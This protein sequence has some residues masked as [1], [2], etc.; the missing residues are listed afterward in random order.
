MHVSKNRQLLRD[1]VSQT[2][3]LGLG[4]WIP[5][6]VPQTPWYSLPPN[7]SILPTLLLELEYNV[8]C[9]I[10][11][12]VTWCEESWYEWSRF[13]QSKIVQNVCYN[14]RIIWTIPLEFLASNPAF[15]VTSV[16]TW[17]LNFIYEIDKVLQ[18]MRDFLPR[19]SATVSPPG[20]HWGL[21]S[22]D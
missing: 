4:F 7:F 19:L 17:Q 11:V 20:P 1:F 21:S 14:V 6:S 22:P 9:N 8:L 10:I 18:L 5:L 16:V 3:I 13:E 12:N 2:S 15:F